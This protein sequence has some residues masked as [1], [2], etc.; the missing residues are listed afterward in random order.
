MDSSPRICRRRF[1]LVTRASWIV[2]TF[3][4][5]G[6]AGFIYQAGSPYAAGADSSGYLN[7]ARLLTLGR[8]TEAARTIPGLDP[9]EWDYFYH[10]P[11]GYVVKP[12][13]VLMAPIY[14]VGL[15]LHYFVA[16]LAVGLEKTAR[17]VN[18]FNVLAAGLLLYALGCQLGLARSWALSGTALLWACPVWIYHSLQ[19]LS[20]C[21]AT[22]WT[23][24]AVVFALRS[25]T[26]PRWALAAGAA[27]AVA[28]LVRPTSIL[29]LAPIAL[30]LGR[31]GRS[32]LLFAL[33]GLP[34][35]VC[36][37]WYN[38]QVYGGVL[39]SGYTQGGQDLWSAFGAQFVSVN[40]RHFA[41]WIPRL[42]SWPVVISA[43]VGLPW[44][45]RHHGRIAWLLLLWVAAFV[46]FYIS[47]FCA[48]ETWGY[49][50]FLLP[51]FPAVI[52]AALL[53]GQR[54]AEY[55]KGDARYGVP[56]ALLAVCLGL[57]VSLARDLAVTDVRQ[58]ERNYWLA[59]HWLDAHVPS[60]AILLSMQ[61][62]GTIMFYNTQPLVRW[63]QID[64]TAFEVL[65][66]TA[67]RQHRALYAPLFA[68]EKSRLQE[69]LGGEWTAV[70][71]AGDV[72]IWQPAVIAA[73]KATP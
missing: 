39:N 42:L 35:A 62:S 24:A 15:P 31:P 72:T 11:L 68:F 67:A 8:L 6:Y 47:Y 26:Q 45:L 64:R 46:G 43:I 13:T 23:L 30:A 19:P 40:L 36:W 65:Q 37:G 34:G 38:F 57:Q 56:I 66:R 69:R 52:L 41:T 50:R 51:A 14:P 70:G 1:P 63:D 20:D 29:A 12:R 58:G 48:G 25:T 9:P 5:L 21:V 32:W 7:S 28:V 71:H 3:V 44:L 60:D 33:G 61:L 53:A 4:A 16:S 49:L 22:T 59:A 17:V 55:L 27:F 73:P 54:A 10:Q 2:L 18:A